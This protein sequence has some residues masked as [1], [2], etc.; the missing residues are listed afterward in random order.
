MRRV[1]SRNSLQKLFVGTPELLLTRSDTRV[2]TRHGFEVGGCLLSM[3]YYSHVQGVP[4]PFSN[5]G[6]LP[7]HVHLYQSA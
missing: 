2:P 4:P 3:L 1:F 6:I 7:P 5:P